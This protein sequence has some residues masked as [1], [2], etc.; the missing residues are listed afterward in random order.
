MENTEVLTPQNDGKTIRPSLGQKILDFDNVRSKGIL[1]VFF[2]AVSVI[3]LLATSFVTFTEPRASIA[4]GFSGAALL[5]ILF[6]GRYEVRYV[7]DIL[8]FTFE[9]PAFVPVVALIILLAMIGMGGAI[10]WFSIVKKRDIKP[11]GWGLFGVAA[12]NL[13]TF[14]VFICADGLRAVNRT[15]EELAFYRVFDTSM[16]LIVFTLIYVVIGGIQLRVDAGMLRRIKKFWFAYLL[17]IVPTVAMLLFNFYPIFMQC[18]ISFKD[19]TLA[20]GIW[21]SE[22]VGMQWFRQIF[23]DPAILRVIGN[24]FYLAILRII[25]GMLPPLILAIFLYDMAFQKVKGVFQTILYI[26]HFFSWVVIYAVFYAFFANTGAINQIIRLI[27]GDSEYYVDFLTNPNN[28]VPIIIFSGIW[29]EMGWGTILYL[30]ALS[31]VDPTLYEAAALDGAGAMRKLWHITLPG[32]S[33]VVVFLFIISMGSILNNGLE[34]VMLFANTVVRERVYIIELW[35]YYQG[36]GDMQYG[37]SSAVG[38]FQSLIG[39]IL[40]LFCNWL[41]RK[42]VGRGLW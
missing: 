30:A 4:A 26:P 21:G 25:A 41:S 28:I 14:I 6:T 15:G 38:F 34:Q 33:S 8:D 11:L 19:Y 2:I 10:A 7:T 36:I 40:I 37:I 3:L 35:V 24:S 16:L 27:V 39:L 42:T 1:V 23:S 31:S 18:I 5:G 32:I 9:V 13:I 22:W 20:G 17:L 29:K 12:L